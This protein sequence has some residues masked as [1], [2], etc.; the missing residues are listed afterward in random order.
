MSGPK[1]VKARCA[2]TGLYYALRVESFD[3]V[4]EVTD[5]VPMTA[6]EGMQ[7]TSEVRQDEYRTHA[8]LRPCRRCGSRRIGGCDCAKDMFA[9]SPDMGYHFNCIYCRELQPDYSRGRAVPG[10]K[11]KGEAELELVQGL[12]AKVTFSN[13]SWLVYDRIK[14][15][16]HKS[17]YDGIEPKE[18]VIADE[19]KIEFH[20]YNVSAMDEGVTYTIDRN[21]DFEIACDVD[22][23]TIQPHPGGSLTIEMGILTAMIDQN[24]GTFLL[25]G[26]VVAKVGSRFSMVLSLTEGGRY[27]VTI[28]GA[29]AAEAFS[30]NRR[31][32]EI[33]FGFS[34]GPHDCH[35]LSH[36]Y[37]T[38]I[39][40]FQTPGG[41]RK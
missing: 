29:K 38:D 30:Q 37:I 17:E 35:L 28:N 22:T 8:N 33:R 13:V 34:H 12:R 11:G 26:K 14:D 18:H 27:A 7:L 21:D 40:M 9:C 4:F 20:G 16:P 2:R 6:Q 10:M 1:V 19:E 39:Q 36:A 23:S 5:A 31:D 3:G 15:H 25:N 41:A 24:G 32:V